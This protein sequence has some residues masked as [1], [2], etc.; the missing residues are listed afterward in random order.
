MKHQPLAPSALRP[1]LLGLVLATSSAFA[2]EAPPPP[3][4]PAPAAVPKVLPTIDLKE[5]TLGEAV[6]Q[7]ADLSDINIVVSN[8][9]MSLPV[10]RIHLRKVSAIGALQAI[11][12][13]GVPIIINQTP[14]EVPGEAPVWVIMG[15][16][17]LDKIPTLTKVFNLRRASPD[18]SPQM[19]RPAS[20]Q[21]PEKFEEVTKAISDAILTALV[22]RMEATNIKS[23]PPVVKIHP[24]TRLMIVSGKPEEVNIASQVICALGGQPVE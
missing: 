4:A 9:V 5:T 17:P 6:E 24:A 2:Q 18:F 15:T 8:D 13:S 22:T 20:D 3:A 11:A 10:P 12:Q 14:S 7:L 1:L 19:S 16:G 23:Q 21:S